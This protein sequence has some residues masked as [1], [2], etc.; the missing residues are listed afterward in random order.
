MGWDQIH[1]TPSA[2][3]WSAPAPKDPRCWAREELQGINFQDL[4]QHFRRFKALVED[5]EGMS[6]K[7]REHKQEREDENIP[8]DNIA[9][10]EIHNPVLTQNN[11]FWGP[12]LV[13]LDHLPPSEPAHYNPVSFRTKPAVIQ[14]ILFERWSGTP[15][16]LHRCTSNFSSCRSPEWLGGAARFT[17]QRAKTSLSIISSVERGGLAALRAEHGG[18]PPPA[19][20][21]NSA[22]RRGARRNRGGHCGDGNVAWRCYDRGTRSATG[23][24]TA[25]ITPIVV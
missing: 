12:T 3:W 16:R 1:V 23:D 7:N 4:G 6:G 10:Q 22:G 21:R 2:D 19:Q 14:R 24:T 5:G 15:L 11:V 9:A 13:S 17:Q 25:R 20:S 18:F 8:I